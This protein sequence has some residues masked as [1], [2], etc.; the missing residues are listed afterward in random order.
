M[1]KSHFCRRWRLIPSKDARGPV[2]LLSVIMLFLTL[3]ACAGR[4]LAVRAMVDV[5]D[6]GIAAYERDDDLDMLEKAFPAHIK[7]MEALLL[8]DPNNRRLLVLLSRSY[9]SYA[10]IF[11]EGR[12]EA[13]RLSSS[14][15]VADRRRAQDLT[16][17]ASRYYRTG[18][19][20]AMRSLEVRYSDARRQLGTIA[21]AD[22]FIQSLDSRDLPALFWYGFNLSADINLNRDSISAVAA[23]YRVEKS[24]QRVLELDET[25]FHGVSHLVLFGYHAARTPAAGGNPAQAL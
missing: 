3:N 19:E 18:T 14:R 1:R 2:A 15:S 6:E 13:A 20:Y 10:F 21:T 16:E 5:V 23:A 4:Q 12:I 17:A 11:F 7:L 25:Y 24:M 22:R 9:A 8:S